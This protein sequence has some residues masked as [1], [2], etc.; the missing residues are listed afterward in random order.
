[1][2]KRCIRYRRVVPFFR[3]AIRAISFA[4]KPSSSSSLEQ[5]IR[6]Q[7]PIVPTKFVAFP[8]CFALLFV[9]VAKQIAS[10]V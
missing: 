5:E 2:A 6:V 10:E 8:L 4:Q 1:M 3:T 7:I 9:H